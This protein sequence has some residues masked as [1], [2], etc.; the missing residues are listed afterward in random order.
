[1]GWG[2][3]V[4][5]LFHAAVDYYYTTLEEVKGGGEKGR[6]NRGRPTDPAT[7]LSEKAAI[8]GA[9]GTTWDYR[10]TKESKN[11]GTLIQCRSRSNYSMENIRFEK[12]EIAPETKL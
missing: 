11:F 5:G 4:S 1:M 7:P 3:S 6:V 2:R 12:F 8:C 9:V 10:V